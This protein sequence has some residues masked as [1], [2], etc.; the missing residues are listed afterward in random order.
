MLIAYM[1][2]YVLLTALFWVGNRNVARKKPRN[3]AVKWFLWT[4]TY[5]SLATM[6]H[7]LPTDQMNFDGLLGPVLISPFVYP[8]VIG[9][10]FKDG[11]LPLAVITLAVIAPFVAAW[12]GHLLAR[13]HNEGRAV[14]K[15]GRTA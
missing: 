2:A 11:S 9:K 10:A 14:I 1:A 5:I 8:M 3:S 4:T 7:E 6:I 13:R 15:G 12:T